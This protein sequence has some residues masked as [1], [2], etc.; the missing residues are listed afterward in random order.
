M[1]NMENGAALTTPFAPRL[2]TNAM[3]LGT[4]RLAINL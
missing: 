1:L 4:M 2:V 3:G